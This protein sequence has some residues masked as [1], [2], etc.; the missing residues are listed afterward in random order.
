M[1]KLQNCAPVKTAAA[2]EFEVTKELDLVEMMSQFR[3]FGGVL[4][5]WLLTSSR[6]SNQKLNVK[7]ESEA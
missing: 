5:L 4:R 2:M 6:W 1:E 7:Y 3:W